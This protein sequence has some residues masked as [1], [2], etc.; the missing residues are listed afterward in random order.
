MHIQRLWVLLA[1]SAV[2]RQVFPFFEAHLQWRLRCRCTPHIFWH[3]WWYRI[4]RDQRCLEAGGVVYWKV[5]FLH[6]CKLHDYFS[7]TRC[8]GSFSVLDMGY[9]VW[10][11][12]KGWRGGESV[13]LPLMWPG[14]KSRRR[15]QMWVEFVVGSRLCSER[16]FSGYFGFPLS[17]KTNI[18]IWYS[19]S[20]RSHVDEEPLCGCATST[21]LF[22]HLFITIYLKLIYFSKR[23][24]SLYIWT[25]FVTNLKNIL[26]LQQIW[27]WFCLTAT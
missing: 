26:S 13:R 9:H 4:F 23:N 3:L 18:F 10:M 17:S 19:N 27:L 7:K 20:T 6:L 11:G 12:S 2:L 21:S 16:F 14:F 1:M 5:W 22:I 25:Y 15:R 24:S 8:V